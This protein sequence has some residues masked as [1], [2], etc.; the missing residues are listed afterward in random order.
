MKTFPR[1]GL[2]VKVCRFSPDSSLLIT[3]G[4]DEKAWIWNLKEATVAALV[5]LILLIK[6]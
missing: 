3:A 4:D 5:Q 2:S 6:Q 1:N